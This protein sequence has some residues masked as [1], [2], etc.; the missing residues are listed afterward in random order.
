MIRAPGR[1]GA[2]VGS[3]RP[4][5]LPCALPAEAPLSRSPRFPHP[6]RWFKW[7]VFPQGT[8]VPGFC[9]VLLWGA[10]ALGWEL[11]GA[12]L[13]HFELLSSS[14]PGCCSQQMPETRR[15]IC[16]GRSFLHVRAEPSK[17]LCRFGWDTSG[18][19][20][21]DPGSGS[22]SA[23]PSLGTTC[24]MVTSQLVP[25]LGDLP[26]PSSARLEA[27]LFGI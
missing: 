21:A 10:L 14:S 9:P 18:A 15:L 8:G 6:Q 11:S 13:R 22:V 17:E 16:C 26:L 7:F 23:G 1:A 27:M 24:S 3:F 4:L 2:S 19:V 5:L 12:A 20:A 25:G